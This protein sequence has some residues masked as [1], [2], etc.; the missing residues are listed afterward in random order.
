MKNTQKIKLQIAEKLLK[1]ALEEEE[2]K[3]SWSL[4]NGLRNLRMEIL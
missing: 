2:L 1:L 4:E 3:N